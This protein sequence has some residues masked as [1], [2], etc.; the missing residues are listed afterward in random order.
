MTVKWGVC[1][2]DCF[3]VT[4]GVRQNGIL[5]PQLINVYIDGLS[6]SLNK[7]SISVSIVG[8]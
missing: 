5:S 8:N 1:I 7:S 3:K 4:N 6:D 2:S